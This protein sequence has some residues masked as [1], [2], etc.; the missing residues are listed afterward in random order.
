[1]KCQVL[2]GSIIENTQDRQT[3]GDKTWTNGCQ[4]WGKDAI[5]GSLK[6]S[7]NV[8]E[9]DRSDGYST[10]KCDKLVNCTLYAI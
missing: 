1:M 2:H 6:S 7:D 8:L 9:L 10:L 5:W 4:C 3:D